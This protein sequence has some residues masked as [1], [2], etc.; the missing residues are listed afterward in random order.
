M[1][2]STTFLTARN[3]LLA[4]QLLGFHAA[5]HTAA[6]RSRSSSSSST[7]SK[8][9]HNGVQMTGADEGHS[10]E[11]TLHANAQKISAS[12]SPRRGQDEYVH[13]VNQSVHHQD[14]AHILEEEGI[15]HSA[16]NPYAKLDRR[17][18]TMDQSI[19]RSDN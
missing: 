17:E 19:E 8:A 7:T 4:A 10:L 12:R 15:A 13:Q 1:N 16:E 3:P 9:G 2:L 6:S 11:E 18:E 5:R 14:I